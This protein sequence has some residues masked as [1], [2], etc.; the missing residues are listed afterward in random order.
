MFKKSLTFVLSI[1][2][3]AGASL[4]LADDMFFIGGSQQVSS[5][6]SGGYY[7]N[8]SS[9][10]AGSGSFDQFAGNGESANPS[11]ENHTARNV[12]IIGGIAAAGVVGTA[13]LLHHLHKKNGGDK[14]QLNATF[15]VSG[16][17][18]SVKADILV[19]GP[20][21]FTLNGIGNKN[22]QTRL[23]TSGTYTISE[24]D[25]PTE[26]ADYKL[27][28]QQ[29]DIEKGKT[30]V[31]LSYKPIDIKKTV[32]LILSSSTRN[33]NSLDI[34][35]SAGDDSTPDQGEIIIQNNGVSD[36]TGFDI[37]V[38]PNNAIQVDPAN[39]GGSYQPCSA[40][41]TDKPL[42]PNSQCGYGINL[43]S[44]QAK[45]ELN[46]ATIKVTAYDENDPNV[47]AGEDYTVVNAVE[48]GSN[49]N[50]RPG[51]WGT[52]AHSLNGLGVNDILAV[53]QYREADNSQLYAATD[54]GVF[55]STDNG[56]TWVNLDK[57]DKTY[58]NPSPH[59][60]TI[61]SVNGN[62]DNEMLPLG[63]TTPLILNRPN[64]LY[65]G[66]KNGLLTSSDGGAT[67]KTDLHLNQDV[68]ALLYEEKTNTLYAG[69]KDDGI[70]AGM[71]N[72]DKSYV[73]WTQVLKGRTVNALLGVKDAAGNTAIYAGTDDGVYESIDGGNWMPD[74]KLTDEVLSL[75]SAKDAD[76]GKTEIYVGTY[77]G[78]VYEQIGGSQTW[79]LIKRP[80]SYKISSLAVMKGVLYAAVLY[81]GVYQYDNQN[82]SWEQVDQNKGLDS[83]NIRV[84]RNVDDKLYAGTDVGIFEGYDKNNADNDFWKAPVDKNNISGNGMPRDGRVTAVTLGGDSN[85]I[86]YVGTDKGVFKSTDGGQ[87]WQ[88]LNDGLSLADRSIKT[89]AYNKVLYIATDTGKVFR[90]DSPWTELTFKFDSNNKPSGQR[91]ISALIVYEDS[92]VAAVEGVGVFQLV[93]KRNKDFEPLNTFKHNNTKKGMKRMNKVS[94]LLAYDGSVFGK[95]NSINKWLIAFNDD[96]HGPTS[97]Y[98]YNGDNADVGWFPGYM[99]H[100]TGYEWSKKNNSWDLVYIEKVTTAITGKDS[101]HQ[102]IYAATKDDHKRLWELFPDK[103]KEFD[104]RIDKNLSALASGNSNN[105]SITALALASGDSTLGQLLFI[106]ISGENGGIYSV[107][108]DK[109]KKLK[110]ERKKIK[111]ATWNPNSYNGGL[112]E[113]KD[114]T[115]LQYISGNADKKTPNELYVGT[116][117]GLFR[118]LVKR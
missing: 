6:D 21:N 45:W 99:Q 76:S 33:L 30:D 75:T 91:H 89:L 101:S 112:E 86:L 54:E 53:K 55:R 85:N 51:L 116:E 44:S 106:G 98:F 42:A 100:F 24:Q 67:W 65:A 88:S 4:A 46:P 49:Y 48:V 84:L 13:L 78:A 117:Q 108:T 105:N 9:A 8:D 104:F 103:H 5:S 114:I 80:C 26:V 83:L 102:V 107:Q 12:A 39:T 18:D 82:K 47:K 60:N 115:Q 74:G 10:P 20:E 43:N 97:F 73:V 87:N 57:I 11:G 2:F 61:I 95:S 79:S 16:L 70:Y 109:V 90:Q 62:H 36:I 32:P 113:I 77:S 63:E 81:A 52:Q 56:V 96:D 23:V 3:L 14:Y 38:T 35:S 71:F 69:T 64:L 25:Y 7:S 94:C 27:D 22:P 50:Y 40:V 34:P 110:G 92:I 59:V 28:K 31:K 93:N 19:Q 29:V 68:R 41:T 58:Q 37:D 72:S 66:T 118:M 111:N 15:T 1:M 17:P